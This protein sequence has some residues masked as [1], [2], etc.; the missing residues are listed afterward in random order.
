[1]KQR[2]YVRYFDATPTL[3]YVFMGD[4]KM[5]ERGEGVLV[6]ECRDEQL[7]NDTRDEYTRLFNE[8]V[9]RANG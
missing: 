4:A 9:E 6:R 7:A 2:F 8:I 3:W 5:E 1:M